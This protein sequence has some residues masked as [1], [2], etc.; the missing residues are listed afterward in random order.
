MLS[1]S[2]LELIEMTSYFQNLESPL[3]DQFLI[4][5]QDKSYIFQNELSFISN[6]IGYLRYP[7]KSNQLIFNLPKFPLSEASIDLKS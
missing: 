2:F 1:L 7:Q 6:I 4:M 5:L 3:Y